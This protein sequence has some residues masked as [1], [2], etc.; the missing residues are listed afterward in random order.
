MDLFSSPSRLP[1]S[2]SAAGIG[3][4]EKNLANRLRKLPGF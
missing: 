4:V 1:E 3:K 2:I